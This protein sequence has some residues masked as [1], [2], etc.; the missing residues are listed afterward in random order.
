[1]YPVTAND[2]LNALSGSEGTARD[3]VRYAASFVANFGEQS[4]N[5]SSGIS[6]GIV[7][8]DIGIKL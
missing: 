3:D 6:F 1:M 8:M 4:G 2:T 7:Q 5:N